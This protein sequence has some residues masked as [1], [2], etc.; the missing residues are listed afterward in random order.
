MKITREFIA[1]F[2]WS[3]TAVGPIETWPTSLKSMVSMIV[4]LPTPAIIFWG[5]TH[6]QI[7]NDGY[8]VIMGPRHPKYFGSTFEECWPETYPIF[9]PSMRKI[10]A[11]AGVVII[12]RTL[13]PLTR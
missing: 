7:Y 10:L 1:T 12:D 3:N 9:A 5:P 2:D 6:T 13:I 11:E 8:A 4:E